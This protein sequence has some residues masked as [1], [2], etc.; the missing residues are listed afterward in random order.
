LRRVLFY[1][2][3]GQVIDVNIET[4]NDFVQ[5]LKMLNLNEWLIITHKSNTGATAID[6]REVEAI[7]AGGEIE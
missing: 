7:A 5:W 1:M 4:G 2:K 3:S 6:L